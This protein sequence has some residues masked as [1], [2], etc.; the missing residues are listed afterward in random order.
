VLDLLRR[1]KQDRYRIVLATHSELPG[2]ELP[3]G[4]AVGHEDGATVIMSPSLPSRQLYALLA[5]FNEAGLP[6][7]SVSPVEP[8]LEDVFLE[9]VRGGTAND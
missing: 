2:I 5:R 3:A 4:A 6:L 1:F 7:R 9:L 8:D